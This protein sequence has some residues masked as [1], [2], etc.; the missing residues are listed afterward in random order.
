MPHPCWPTS[1]F[2]QWRAKSSADQN[3]LLL[4]SRGRSFNAEEINRSLPL[5]LVLINTFKRT[6]EIFFHVFLLFRGRKREKKYYY[7]VEGGREKEDR[8]SAPAAAWS[9]PICTN[10]CPRAISRWEHDSYLERNRGGY[11]TRVPIKRHAARFGGPPV[12]LHLTAAQ[13]RGTNDNVIR[14][15]EGKFTNKRSR[16]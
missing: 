13:K 16:S 3:P 6:R 11:R 14:N 2:Q 7:F 5:F 15:F 8:A 1:A 12:C 9:A 10:T 4:L